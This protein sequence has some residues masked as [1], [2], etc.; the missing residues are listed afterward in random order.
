MKK[1]LLSL[2]AST[3]VSLG[4]F[5]QGY[6]HI[7]SKGTVAP[8]SMNETSGVSAIVTGTSTAQSSVLSGSQNLPFNFTFYGIP[9]NQFKVSSSG[10][11]T[12]DVAQTTDV[13]A[14]VALPAAGAPKNAIFAFWDN[15]R[16]QTIT[17]GSTTFPSDIRTWTLGTSPNRVQVIQWRLTQTN[18]GSN[19]TNV[20]YFAVRLYEADNHFDVIHNYGFG[21]FSATVGCQNG[22]GTVGYQ[23]GGSPNQNFGGN[24]G[25][26]DATLSD[27]YSFY[28]GTQAPVAMK[29][30]ADLTADVASSSNTAGI[31]VSVRAA[32]HGSTSITSGTFN[33]TVNGGATVGTSFSTTM[34]PSGG[35]AALSSSTNYVALAADAGTTKTIKIWISG[36]NGGAISSDT[37]TTTIFNNKGVTGTKRVLLEEGSGAWCGWCPDGH[38][39]MH[40]I[41]AG[42]A[43]VV[44]VIH[45]NSDGM[46]T[47]EGNTINSTFSTGYPYGMVDRVKFADQDE[48][49][50]SRSVWATKV[51]ERLNATTP[52]NVTITDRTYDPATRTVSFKV[53]ANFV[54][55]ITGDLRLNAF[56]VENNVRGPKIS[57]T[58]MTWN[59]RNYMNSAEGGSTGY[60]ALKDL[61]SYIFGYKH[62]HTVRRVPSGA[63][64]T[65]SVIPTVA[66]ENAEYSQTYTW[67]IPAESVITYDA[68]DGSINDEHRLTVTGHA[69][70]NKHY[71]MK[72]VG[73]VSLYNADANKHEVLNVIEV[74]LAWNTGVENAASAA[75]MPATVYPNPANGL[76]SVTFTTSSTSKVEV[77]LVDITGKKVMDINTAEYAK[78]EH[79]VFFD[80]ATLTNGIYFVNIKGENEVATKRLVIAK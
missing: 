11:L 78:G 47:T 56:I 64:G 42:N 30:L 4:A 62:Q 8:Y 13:N 14:N 21:T 26:Y 40:D 27:V 67:T 57:A 60:Q 25:S 43:N 79:S 74:P 15:L 37:L 20:T 39:R 38:F 3:L 66:A 28:A 46:T 7:S 49:G 58:N 29:L 61:P 36:I 19:S 48:P 65:A 31:P 16:L 70:L 63:W 44:G 68:A 59:Q 45:H 50:L 75:T 72:I 80:A 52:V 5:A 23:I 73:F 77:T 71:D 17:S 9:Y 12:F 2:A 24:N 69:G 22:D 10:Y 41:L 54:D 55:Y 34:S 35:T 76:T 1:G 33:Y 32:N 51:A 53:K 6:Y 18:D